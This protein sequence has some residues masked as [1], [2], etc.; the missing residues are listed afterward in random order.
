M[1]L[2]LSASQVSLNGQR[3]S[4]GDALARLGADSDAATRDFV[5]SYLDDLADEDFNPNLRVSLK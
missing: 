5:D 3:V 1:G 4:L 2:S